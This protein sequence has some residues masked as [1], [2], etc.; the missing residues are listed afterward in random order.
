MVKGKQKRSMKMNKSSATARRPRGTNLRPRGR[1]VHP[2]RAG[3]KQAILVDLL[4]RP[5]GATMQ[6]LLKGLSGGRQP[7]KEVTVRSGFGWDLRRKGY[8]VRSEV[9]PNGEERFYLV[10]P[11]GKTVPKHITH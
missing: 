9:K 10:L 2:C 3:T 6:E 4:K 1:A 7:W 5:R 8:G 11:K